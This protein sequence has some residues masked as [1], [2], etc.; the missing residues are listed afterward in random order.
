MPYLSISK[1]LLMCCV[2]GGLG[3]CGDGKGPDSNIKYLSSSSYDCYQAPAERINKIKALPAGFISGYSGGQLDVAIGRVALIPDR[4]LNHLL[5]TYQTGVLHGIKGTFTFFAA[6]VTYLTSGRTKSG[7]SEMVATSI[8]TGTTQSGFA[9]Q[10]EIGHAVEIVAREAAQGGAYSDFS[11]ALNK[12]YGEL[13]SKGSLI[14]SYAKSKPSESWAEAYAN[15]YC[16]PDSKAFIQKN[17]PFTY[18]FLSAVLVP[19]LWENGAEGSDPVVE[20]PAASPVDNALPTPATK[21]NTSNPFLNW[22]RKLLGNRAWFDMAENTTAEPKENVIGNPTAGQTANINVALINPDATD[23]EIGIT[24]SSLPT[25]EKVLICIEGEEA[26]KKKVTLSAEDR[27]G[28]AISRAEIMGRR[29]YDVKPV[30]AGQ[31]SI[32]QVPWML[33]GYDN[34]DQLIATRKVG[35]KKK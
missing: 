1:K 19:P 28:A 5:W 23:G 24:F 34:N 31:R 18:G 6:G 8:T 27:A 2:A 22:L 26:C 15:Y 9:L 11:G 12:V 10:H 30:P 20:T 3:G 14:R 21:T 35:F 7:F 16:S 33:L 17:L 25:I 32:F 29:F 13:M 4:D